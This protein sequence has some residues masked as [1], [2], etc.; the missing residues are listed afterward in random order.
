MC[1]DF[2]MKPMLMEA[3]YQ[4]WVFKTATSLLAVVW[5]LKFFNKE[6]KEQPPLIKEAHVLKEKVNALRAEVSYSR[7]SIDQMGDDSW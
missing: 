4:T 7:Q 5:L 3:V 1:F 6:H 2:S